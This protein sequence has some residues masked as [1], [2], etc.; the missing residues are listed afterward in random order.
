MTI[1]HVSKILMVVLLIST[2]LFISPAACSSQREAE[3]RIQS[4]EE[5]VLNCY[6]AAY[7]AEKAGANVSELLHNLNE[8]GWLLSQAKHAYNCEDYD[9][10]VYFANLSLTK[11]AGLVD[12]ANGLRIDAEQTH[13]YDFMI[14]FV[15]SA[16]GAVAILVVGY[17]V[18]VFLKRREKTVRV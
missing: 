2:A 15:G 17:G 1:L 16:V 4:V 6:R 14:N 12:K 13:F 5:E 9:L 8:A 11:L 18:W 10:A 3:S 7:E